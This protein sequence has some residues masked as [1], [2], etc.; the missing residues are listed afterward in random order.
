MACWGPEHARAR[1]RGVRA[2]RV[3]VRV[4]DARS[5]VRTRNMLLSVLLSPCPRCCPPGPQ[6][7]LKDKWRNLKKGRY[8][9]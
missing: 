9:V 2:L 7:D 6:M 4:R 5:C 3:C 8:V 1:V